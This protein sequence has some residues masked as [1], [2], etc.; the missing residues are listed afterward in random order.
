MAALMEE[1][2]IGE[3]QREVRSSVRVQFG[4]WICWRT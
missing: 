4:I 2:R 3:I 1:L